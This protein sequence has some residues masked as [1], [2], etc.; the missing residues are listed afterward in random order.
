MP[1]LLTCWCVAGVL[2]L[3]TPGRATGDSPPDEPTPGA[4]TP[5][6]TLDLGEGVVM[7]FAL[8]PAGEFQMGSPSGAGDPDESPPRRVRITRPF[9]LGVDEVTQAQWQRLMPVN[10]S[11]FAG[12]RRPVDNVSWHEALRFIE[13]LSTLSGRELR[14]PTEAEWEYACRA[15][16]GTAWSFGDDENRCGEYAW[17]MSNCGAATRAAGQ[18]TANAFGLQDL[19]GNVSEWC[20]D[21]YA[22]PDQAGDSID[23]TGP[24]S[25]TARVLR[26]GNWSDEARAVRSAARNCL[27]PAGRT[28]GTGFRCLLT[29]PTLSAPTTPSSK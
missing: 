27:D 16:T 14:L 15:G 22:Q 18:K 1:R 20:A 8:V 17:I 6:V 11:R 28:D 23:P 21:W 9:Y 26:G 13:R 5:V 29:L 7:R 12:P 19:H 25:G 3:A 24:K 2:A 10:P 4:L